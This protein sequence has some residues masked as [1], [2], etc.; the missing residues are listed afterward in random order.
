MVC[1]DGAVETLVVLYNRLGQHLLMIPATFV[2]TVHDCFESDLNLVVHMQ[3]VRFTV[4]FAQGARV[5]QTERDMYGDA[6]GVC[7]EIPIT[8][9]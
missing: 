2:P 8:L 3:E 1:S 9:D 6:F 5:H 7:H 4:R